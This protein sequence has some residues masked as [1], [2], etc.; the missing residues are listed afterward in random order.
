MR[1]AAKEAGRDPDTIEVSS[2]GGLDLDTVKRYA[3]LGVSRFIVP[4]LG[5]DLDTLRTQ[6]GRF[7]ETVIAHVVAR[8]ASATMRASAPARRAGHEM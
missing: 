6:L 1:A 2:G 5:F 8:T 3:D 4:P 7:S